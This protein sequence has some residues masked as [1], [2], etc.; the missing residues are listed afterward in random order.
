MKKIISNLGL[1]MAIFAC[2][3]TFCACSSDDDEP[4]SADITLAYGTWVCTSSTDTNGSDYLKDLFVGET[5]TINSDKTYTSS[6]SSIGR[7]GTWSVSGNTFIATSS[8]GK[9]VSAT[10]AVNST[11]LKLSGKASNGYSFD[12][13]FSK[14]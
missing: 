14:K 12:Y 8:T 11:M 6:S 2:T 1:L 10:F 9:S 3:F 4:T 13:T 7:T 5:L